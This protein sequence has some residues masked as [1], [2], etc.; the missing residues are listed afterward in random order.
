MQER[1]RSALLAAGDEI[2]EF[3]ERAYVPEEPG[4]FRP[5]L[6]GATPAGA[7]AGLAPSCRAL[8]IARTLGLWDLVDKEDQVAWVAF[9]CDFQ[10]K[11]GSASDPQ[12]EGALLDPEV[13]AAVGSSEPR[14]P[15]W[16]RGL[17]RA[18]SPLLDLARSST[19]AATSALAAVDAHPRTPYRRLPADPARLEAEL[20]RSDGSD[21]VQAAARSADLVALVMSHGR[22]FLEL[23][24]LHRLREA[25]ARWLEGLADP[26][27]GRF[28]REAPAPRGALLAATAHVLDAFEWLGRPAP[29]PEALIDLCLASRPGRDCDVADWARVLHHCSRSTRHRRAE[30]AGP[31][32][33]ALEEILA[34][35][36]SDG[37]WSAH[38]AGMAT[39]D[40]PL[41][42]SD[43]RAGGDLIGTERGCAA[44]AMLVAVLEWDAPR[45]RVL[46]R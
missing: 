4:R 6:A 30:L 1:V 40:G 5:C 25:A 10:T 2:R 22:H 43:G 29:R 7:R 21:P 34:H 46:R 26:A 28:L 42:I 45:W 44:A 24:Q 13:A 36:H 19:R 41:E 12:L 23:T 35:R 37:G 15:R 38:R 14:L 20:R 3:L 17:S 16:A 8:R 32:L 18:P 39:H 11:E 27:K 31:A 9:I 33:Y